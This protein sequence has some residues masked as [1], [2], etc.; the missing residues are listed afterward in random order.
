MLQKASLVIILAALLSGCG[1]K[2]ENDISQ[3]SVH[4]TELLVN[5]LESNGDYLNSP[6]IPALIGAG[7]VYNMLV[8]SNTHIIDLRPEEE[9]AAG[10][11]MHSVNVTPDRILNHF[12][13]HIDPASFDHIVLVCNNA[14]LSGFVNAVMIFLG[15]DN[16]YTMRFGL[17]AWDRDIAD[18]HWLAALSNQL[19]GKLEKRANPKNQAGELPAI[20][21]G[22]SDGYHI[23]RARAAELLQT[24]IE[25]YNLTLEEFTSKADD[26]YKIKYWPEGFYN[27]GHLPG[28]IQYTPKSSLH[29]NEYLNTLPAG[30]PIVVSCF[31][32]HHS[33]YVIAF[34]RLLGYDAHNL[35]YGANS[36]IHNIMKT[37]QSDTRF[38]SEDHVLNLPFSGTDRVAPP[39]VNAVQEE[40]IP[41]IGGC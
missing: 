6:F 2:A 9:F 40:S 18:K 20:D 27:Q 31:S 21:T 4:E 17:S 35:V 12:E 28:A 23:L 5:Y 24:N 8:A 16:V 11:I 1:K 36:Y 33:A 41:I 34:L 15:Y 22:H 19:D 13:R 26:F 39:P 3:P 10:H 32:G 38:F 7:D 29:S 30:M 25:A 37:T 14:M